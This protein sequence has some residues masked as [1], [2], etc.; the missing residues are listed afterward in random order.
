MCIRDSYDIWHDRAVFHFLTIE[1]EK[2]RYKEIATKKINTGGYLIIGTF[3]ED[4]P[5]KCSG[6][7]ISRYSIDD[8]KGFFSKD[9]T[10]IESHKIL[11]N[12]P[13]DTIQ[14]FNFCIF[15]KL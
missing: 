6:L 1:S 4:G 14:K 11:H 12:T 3:A 9:F 7:E 8:L 13:F 10:F 15:K 5:L 2:I